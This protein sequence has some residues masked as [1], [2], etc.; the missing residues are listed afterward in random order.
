MEVKCGDKKI[1]YVPIRLEIKDL[2]ENF[3]YDKLQSTLLNVQC[4]WTYEL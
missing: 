2:V 3:F 4:R 1:S